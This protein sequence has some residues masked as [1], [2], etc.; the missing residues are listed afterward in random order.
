[1]YLPVDER[2]DRQLTD[3]IAHIPNAPP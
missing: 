2:R 3:T 1:L